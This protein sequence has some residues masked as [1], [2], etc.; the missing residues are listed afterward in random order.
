M[1]SMVAYTQN[2]QRSVPG[3]YSIDGWI[4]VEDE[5]RKSRK[6]PRSAAV[7]RGKAARG[8]EGV[9]NTMNNWTVVMEG[10]KCTYSITKDRKAKTKEKEI[11]IG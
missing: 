8:R 7:H 11:N 10:S 1:A 4:E 5:P 2:V 9:G 3:G 6:L